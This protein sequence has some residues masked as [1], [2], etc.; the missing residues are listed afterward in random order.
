VVIAMEGTPTK[1]RALKGAVELASSA[2]LELI[3][4]HVDDVSSIPSFSD[5]VQHEVSAFAHE[6]LA[7]FVP[8]APSA[9]L[10]LRVGAP[11]EEI[12]SA[13]AA[14]EPDL[15]AMGW[16]Q[17]DDPS[18]GEVAHELLERCRLPML[19]VALDDG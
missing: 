16:P 6:F 10:E 18:R 2:G 19:L 14:I 5:Q 12:L 8:G 1:A 13:V 17:T 3:V 15:L 9:Q 11:V 7:R 4:V